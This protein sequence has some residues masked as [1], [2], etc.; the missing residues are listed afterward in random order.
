VR[1]GLFDGGIQARHPKNSHCRLSP[2]SGRRNK[3]QE[4]KAHRIQ[5]FLIMEVPFW[6]FNLP[7]IVVIRAT[8]PER[9]GLKYGS[10]ESSTTGFRVDQPS[11]QSPQSGKTAIS[12]ESSYRRDPQK[13]RTGPTVTGTPG[14][15]EMRR[16]RKRC[17]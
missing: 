7:F 6:Q 11:S 13:R 8:H 12:D 1:Q 15:I 2:S 3:L 14:G 5:P 9:R 10:Q 4:L 16:N 17:K